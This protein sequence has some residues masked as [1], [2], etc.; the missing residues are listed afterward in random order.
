MVVTW[1]SWMLK[2]GTEI[3]LDSG[4]FLKVS[5]VICRLVVSRLVIKNRVA[6]VFICTIAYICIL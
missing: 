3:V 5:F 1:S 4:V 6:A 2:L